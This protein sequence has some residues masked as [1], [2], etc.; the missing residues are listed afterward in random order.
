MALKPGKYIFTGITEEA[1]EVSGSAIYVFNSN[2]NI[3][4]R[5][6][7][8]RVGRYDAA[9]EITETMKVGI[10][11]KLFS[12]KVKLMIR[13]AE[14]ADNTYEPYKE[15]LQ[16]QIDNLK[17]NPVV[18]YD[19][20]IVASINSVTINGLFT[21]NKLLHVMITGDKYGTRQYLLP[22]RANINNGEAFLN[23]E[24]E[25]EN[26][27][28]VDLVHFQK[29]D[30]NTLGVFEKQASGSEKYTRIVITKIF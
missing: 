10:E 22:I 29:I 11:I 20:G 25:D 21:N 17:Q 4:A 27:T 5:V 28:Q 9:F 2:N 1:T 15:S 3:L 23:I 18:L 30:D 12:Q 24:H 8:N 26:G 14:I 6:F 16:E 19:S 13:R 7:T